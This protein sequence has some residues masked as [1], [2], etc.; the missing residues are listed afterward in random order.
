MQTVVVLVGVA[1]TR[2]EAGRHGWRPYRKPDASARAVVL[3][4]PFESADYREGRIHGLFVGVAYT[5][6]YE[7]AKCK[8]ML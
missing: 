3:E 8:R 2:P 5:R 6:P 1:Y 4:G 7:E